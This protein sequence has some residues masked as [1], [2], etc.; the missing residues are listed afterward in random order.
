[1]RE[2]PASRYYEAIVLIQQVIH[3]AKVTEPSARMTANQRAVTAGMLDKV[4]SAISDVNLPVTKLT[5]QEL[6]TTL[7]WLKQEMTYFG[8]GQMLVNLSETMRR[9]LQVVRFLTLSPRQNEFY[10]PA[11][12]FFGP[13]IAAK[14]PSVMDDVGEAAKCIAL[15]RPTAAVFHTMHIVERALRA[16]HMCLSLSI[17][18]NPSWGIWLSQIREERIKR[19]DKRW[20]ENLFFQDIWQH[21]NSIKDAQRDPTMHVESTH[22]ESEAI[23]IFENS[24]ALMGKISARMDEIGN[25]KA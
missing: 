6:Q 19:G 1:M 9:E 20:P 3:T 4:K 25:P 22:T 18:N 5:L 21:L 12:P 11:N 16:V 14:F 23:L 7:S 24:R 15:S 2:I 13:E 17:P 8:C 10:D